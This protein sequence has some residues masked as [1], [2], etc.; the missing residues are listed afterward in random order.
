MTRISG[1]PCDFSEEDEGGVACGNRTILLGG[2][3]IGTDR[4]NHGATKEGWR[5]EEGEAVIERVTYR[6]LCGRFLWQVPVWVWIGTAR[7]AGAQYAEGSGDKVGSSQYS[8][9]APCALVC[10]GF[11]SAAGVVD[12]RVCGSG[13]T[14]VRLSY[15]PKG[16]FV[17]RWRRVPKRG[18]PSGSLGKPRVR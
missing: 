4:S 14:L 12:G 13:S 5:N 11:D 15:H 2:V 3:E 18:L 6:V 17:L 1:R 9:S 8:V 7:G 16:S 10:L